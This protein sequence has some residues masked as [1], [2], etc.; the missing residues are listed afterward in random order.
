M[1]VT[2]KNLSDTKVQLKLAADADLLQA[3]KHKALQALARN[4]KI[5][6]FR[7]GKVPP[8]MVEKYID[9]SRLQSEFLERAINRLYVAAL[10]QE[11]LRPMQQPKVTINKFVP[12]DTLEVEA[13]VEVVGQVKL[14]DY[15]KIKL[16]KQP[17]SVD[18]K[19]V[20]EVIANLRT[21]AADKQEVDRASAEGDE[22]W[23]DFTGVDAKTKDPIK[24]AEGKNYP[25]VLGSNTFIPGFEPNLV[26]LKAGD[27]KTFVLTFPKDYG[28]KALQ[29]RKV[30]FTVTVK[31]VQQITE[32]RVDDA[33]AATVGPFKTVAEL[34]KDIK[35]ELLSRKQ[36]EADQTYADDLLGKITDKSKV[37]IPDVLVDE[38]IERL[39]RELRQSL[40]YRGL[41]WQEY[42]EA[43]G[44]TDQTYR[45]KQRPIAQTRLK[46]S[47]VIAAISEA[48]NIE[49]STD[50][51][52]AQLRTLRSRY[53][54]KQMQAELGKPEA[55]SQVASRLL[56]Q[57]TIAKLVDYAS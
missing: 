33:F 35:Q 23:I 42:L 4:V 24:G 57:K 22:T 18:A 40:V 28:L 9:P 43:E 51:L 56:T 31:K 17:V 25:V 37:A 8:N 6:G 47:L 10:E 34:K 2:K 12:F 41:T 36:I 53:P 3:E 1:Q 52:D 54:D 19:E 7:P 14:P 16:A 27:Q 20:D 45:D 29:N 13:E 50:E 15:K 21:R 5:Q 30:E 11:Q 55:R 26:G 49:I 32:P 46:T 48:E 44:L 39:E 38:E